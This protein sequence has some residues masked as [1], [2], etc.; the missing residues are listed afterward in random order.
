MQLLAVTSKLRSQKL[1][2]AA[3]VFNGPR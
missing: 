3:A 1:F 2:A